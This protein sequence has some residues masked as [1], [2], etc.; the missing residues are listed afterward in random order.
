MS[1]EGYV[2]QPDYETVHKAQE[3]MDR[4]ENGETITQA[5]TELPVDES[6]STDDSADVLDGS[7]AYGDY[8]YT[9]TD[10]SYGY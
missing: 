2:M 7:S 10:S 3:L 4:V 8:T 1:M 6:Y 9:G 5:D